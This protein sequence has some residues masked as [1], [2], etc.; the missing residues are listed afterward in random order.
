METIALII[1]AAFTALLIIGCWAI[2]RAVTNA[3]KGN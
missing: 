2:H 3:Y 1:A